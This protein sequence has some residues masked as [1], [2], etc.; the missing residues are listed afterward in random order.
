MLNRLLFTICADP[1]FL[2]KNTIKTSYA[3][4]L[5]AQ[6]CGRECA[7]EGPNTVVSTTISLSLSCPQLRL[8]R[9]FLVLITTIAKM[10][11]VNDDVALSVNSLIISIRVSKPRTRTKS[12]VEAA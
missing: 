2:A 3:L 12:K 7:K 6:R 8:A 1:L 9:L 5:Q 4:A 11:P 10:V